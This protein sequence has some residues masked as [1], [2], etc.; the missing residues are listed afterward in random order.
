MKTMNH[1]TPYSVYKR[2]AFNMIFEVISQQLGRYA[3]PVRI[4]PP[5]PAN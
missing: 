4:Y 1:E 5:F 2:L 3:E